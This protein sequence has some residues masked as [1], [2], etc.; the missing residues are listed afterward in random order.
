MCVDD[1]KVKTATKHIQ[2]VH[3]RKNNDIA[4]S[5]NNLQGSLKAQVMRVLCD[6]FTPLSIVS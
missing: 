4:F 3:H 5:V 1:I 6:C 2:Q